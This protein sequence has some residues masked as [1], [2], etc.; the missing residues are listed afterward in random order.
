MILHKDSHLDHGLTPAQVEY[1]KERFVDRSAFFIES[2]ELP[3]HL[4]TVPCALYGEVMGDEVHLDPTG[5]R[6]P[7]IGKERSWVVWKRRGERQYDSRCLHAPL[8]PTR[9]VTVIAGPH[10]GEACVLYTAFGGPR[11]PKEQRDPTLKDEERAES[12]AFWD[13]H[14]LAI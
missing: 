2:F 8:R 14:A 11:T 12:E 5:R 7:K 6:L 13:K 1:I 3:E 4:G 9:L 10:D